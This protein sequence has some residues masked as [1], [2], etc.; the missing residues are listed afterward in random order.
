MSVPAPEVIGSASA[1]P[2]PLPD[3]RHAM[4]VER[5]YQI[6]A[7]RR[8]IRVRR[9]LQSDR[10]RRARVKRHVEQTLLVVAGVRAGAGPHHCDLVHPEASGRLHRA[11]QRSGFLV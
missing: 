5:E 2:E 10:V 6:P 9:H 8:Q 1:E 7:R 11:A 4:M 3:R